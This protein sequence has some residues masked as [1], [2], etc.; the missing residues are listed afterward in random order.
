MRSVVSHATN[1]PHRQHALPLKAQ[2]LWER[3][4]AMKVGVASSCDPRLFEQW[5]EKVAVTNGRA[6]ARRLK[7]MQLDTLVVAHAR[8]ASSARP[9]FDLG[10]PLK[11]PTSSNRVGAPIDGEKRRAE[12]IDSFITKLIDEETRTILGSIANIRGCSQHTTHSVRASLSQR[13]MKITYQV[14]A[15]E[16]KL[17]ALRATAGSIV[18]EIALLTDAQLSSLADDF[19]DAL[20]LLPLETIS[21]HYPVWGRLR[22]LELKRWRAQTIT[23]FERLG[24]DRVSL[25]RSFGIDVDDPVVGVG[26]SGDTH[27]GGRSVHILTFSSGKK[28]VYKPRS[29]CV[30]VWYRELLRWISE[31]PGVSLGLDAPVVIDND[32]YSWV[33]F[34]PHQKSEDP[35]IELRF[36]QRMGMLL[37]LWGLFGGSD[38]HF[39]NVIARGD[40]PYVV[41]TETLFDGHGLIAQHTEGKSGAQISAERL[42]NSVR[43]VGFLPL[44]M[45]PNDGV[46]YFDMS[47]IGLRTSIPAPFYAEDAEERICRHLGI[48][49]S[50]RAEL[51]PQGNVPRERTGPLGTAL[52]AAIEKGYC[53]MYDVL[54][55]NRGAVVRRIRA[56]AKNPRA[57]VRLVP[58]PT[59]LYSRL[60]SESLSAQCLKDGARRSIEIDRLSIKFTD[61]L[62]SRFDGDVLA[63][64][65]EALENLDIPLF[66]LPLGSGARGPR[67]CDLQGRISRRRYGSP[68]QAAIASL[69]G[70]SA[71][72]KAFQLRIVRESLLLDDALRTTTVTSRERETIIEWPN[73]AP[74]A[75]DVWA[76]ITRIEQMVSESAF[77]GSDNSLGWVAPLPLS[78]KGHY[79]HQSTGEGLY[80]GG[81]GVALFYAALFRVSGDPAFRAKALNSIAPIVRSLQTVK[82]AT[83]DVVGLHLRELY[84][85]MLCSHLLNAP[86]LLDVVQSALSRATAKTFSTDTA[87]DVI[88]GSA[89]AILSLLSVWRETGS[90]L[91]LAIATQAGDHLLE[92]RSKTSGGFRAWET[93]DAPLAGFAHGVAGI[94]LSLERLSV[95]SGKLRFRDASQEALAYER[96]L[97]DPAH[98]NWA[99]LRPTATGGPATYYPSAWCHGA[100][101]IGMAYLGISAVRSDTALTESLSLARQATISLPAVQGDTVCC[102]MFG[103]AAFFDLLARRRGDAEAG[104]MRDRIVTDFLQR[105]P[106]RAR[107]VEGVPDFI[108]STG[109]FNGLS[110]VGYELI[111]M[112]LDPT[113]PP[114]MLW[115]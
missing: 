79:Q 93:L 100:T 47:A 28:I 57:R 58:R 96:T 80:S 56:L 108:D 23:M 6:F 74:K 2:S 76:H 1:V 55:L 98:R 66:D 33:E 85:L 51:A 50:S 13:V 105:G 31:M 110:G 37:A 38:G 12:E 16:F 46:E 88:G 63:A 111:R 91:S 84:P 70:S 54:H 5:R 62:P 113:L 42:V 77:T 114:V 36:Y 69:K 41:D 18:R 99:D 30:D 11:R 44:Y 67:S 3:I 40:I 97:Y 59:H 65:I 73:S 9:G 52:V 45:K 87:F 35:E 64:E 83:S 106:Q 14:L 61:R 53:E 27:R 86:F 90:G 82:R 49:G 78:N 17:Y 104:A 25:A 24:R 29:G 95:A 21:L 81:S 89:G 75:D 4:E 101:G 72:D 107:L 8:S 60:L 10:L 48:M 15:H 7:L 26:D 102:G 43:R 115:E 20:S 71:E 112:Y 32:D 34:I 92:K 103:R 19:L 22:E 109:F 94:A 68:A 39:E